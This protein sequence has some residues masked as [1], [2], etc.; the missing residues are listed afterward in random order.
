MQLAPG[1]RVPLASLNLQDQIGVTVDVSGSAST[2]APLCFVLDAQSR[3][4]QPNAVVSPAQPSSPDGA[5]SWQ[6]PR[7]TVQLGRLAPGVE[8]LA[9]ALVPENADLRGVQRGE[10]GLGA[11]NGPPA[12]TWNFSGADFGNERAIIAVEVY[13]HQGAWRLMVNGQGFADGL[14][15]L[16]KHFGG[17][18]LPDLRAPAAPPAPPPAAPQ[19]PGGGL[20]L[21]R[22]RGSR[23]AALHHRPPIRPPLRP[24]AAST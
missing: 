14:G 13:R 12:A 6:A 17:A 8:R 19:R 7:F 3:L 4:T 20:D 2:Y 24:A 15:G 11:P 16:V 18:G 9:F 23:A 5:V 21:S 22:P 1:Q 10:V